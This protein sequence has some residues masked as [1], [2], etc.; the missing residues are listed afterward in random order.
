MESDMYSYLLASSLLQAALKLVMDPP[1]GLKANLIQVM[2]QLPAE[3]AVT[4]KS[5]IAAARAA[6]ESR[7][8]RRPDSLTPSRDR[9]ES[10]L[11][12]KRLILR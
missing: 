5:A 6:K 11:P 8:L 3:V 10:A 4:G 2:S 9:A 12:W 7:S 1:V